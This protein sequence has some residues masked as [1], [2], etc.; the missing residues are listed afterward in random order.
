MKIYKIITFLAYPTILTCVYFVNPSIE[1]LYI[2][3]GLIFSFLFIN[4]ASRNNTRSIQ[5]F[6][7]SRNTIDVL[8]LACYVILLPNIYETINSIFQGEFFDIGVKIAKARYSGESTMTIGEQ[9]A[10]SITF[11]LSLLIGLSNSSIIKRRHYF[12]YAL[13]LLNSLAGL[14]RAAFL[15]NIVLLISGLLIRTSKLTRNYSFAKIF[16]RIILIGLFAFLIYAIPQYG[17]VANSKNAI[18]IVF[19]KAPAYSTRIYFAFAEFI[20]NFSSDD[21][22]KEFKT[23]GVLSKVMGYN[24]IQ[25][26]YPM[27]RIPG[28]RT[29]V[30]TLL[31]GLIEDFGFLFLPFIVF[32]LYSGSIYSFNTCSKIRFLITFW[33]IPFFLYPFYSIFYFNTVLLGYIIFSMITLV[34]KPIYH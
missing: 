24:T 8:F 13:I 9:I 29:N 19:Q 27:I 17:R 20:K 34:S 5:S 23:F 25:G 32:V 2:I 1:F 11:A 22:S 26:T 30:F 6:S 18:E 31:R 15:I 12:L 16:L 7:Y 21:F 28:G 4:S 10:G 14:A 33:T 3:S